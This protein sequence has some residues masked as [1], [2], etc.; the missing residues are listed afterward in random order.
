MPP[1]WS[2]SAYYRR[3]ET[4]DLKTLRPLPD[5][6]AVEIVD[7]TRLPHEYVTVALASAADA[8]RA[9]RT[10]QVR[11][12]PLIGATAAYGLAL[13]LAR[14]S[15]RRCAR[16]CDRVASR[17]AADG[18]QPAL[19]ARSRTRRVAPL[20]A[21]GARRWRR[22][23]KPT[24]SP[25]KTSPP[26][27]RSA[28]T[29]CASSKRSPRAKEAPRADPHP[30]QRRRARHA[31]LGNRD[32]ADLSRACA[33]AS[34]LHVWVSETRPRLQGARLTA[35]ELRAHGVPHHADRRRRRRGADAAAARRSRAGRR[36]PRDPQRRRVQQ[37]RHLR[38]SARGA[39]QR[40]A[41]VRRGSVGDDRLD[42]RRRR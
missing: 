14:R 39:R 25:A 26:T 13:A 19:G 9:I 24:P 21:L 15:V 6:D 17:H 3:V 11:G 30:L 29:G 36:R 5:R 1:N 20:A 28:S 37:D 34:R 41:D 4:P 10:M 12:A 32:R 23:T 40:R 33:P 38:E 2:A 16:R 18:G 27:A 22:G 31:R 7:Q 35:W 42:A 8:A